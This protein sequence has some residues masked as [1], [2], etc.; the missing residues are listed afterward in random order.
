M[1][2]SICLD[3]KDISELVISVLAFS[4]KLSPISKQTLK[5]YLHL[6]YIE[7]QLHTLILH[8]HTASKEK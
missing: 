5:Q 4:N 7:N 1:L 8:K 2:H 6:H 3:Y